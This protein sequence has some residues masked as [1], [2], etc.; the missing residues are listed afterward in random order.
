MS[1]MVLALGLLG[2]GEPVAGLGAAMAVGVDTACP[3]H[4]ASRSN[5]AI[6]IKMARLGHSSFFISGELFSE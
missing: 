4:P 3:P 1:E 5:M 2:V 6:K